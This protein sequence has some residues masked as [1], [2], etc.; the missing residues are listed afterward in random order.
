MNKT[1]RT[2]ARYAFTTL[3]AV[4]G[5]AWAGTGLNNALRIPIRSWFPL[6]V[7]EPFVFAFGGAIGGFLFGWLGLELMNATFGQG[8]KA[9]RAAKRLNR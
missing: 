7:Y 5:F 4:Y 9:R 6:A 2:A 3:C 8:P 1:L